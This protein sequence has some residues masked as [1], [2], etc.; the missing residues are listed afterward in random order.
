MSEEAKPERDAYEPPA[1]RMLG[2]VEE[3]TQAAVPGSFADSS[4]L[5]DPL[6]LGYRALWGD[7]GRLA[8]AK[9]EDRLEP[10]TREKDFPS[11]LNTPGAN[12]EDDDFIE[13][14]IYGAVHRRGVERVVASKKKRKAD[15]ALLKDLKRKLREI[16]VELE[17][18]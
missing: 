13:V 9:L 16:D 6:P 5:T 11:I 3:L 17:I 14:H 8:A 18:R 4:P 10:D 15:Q 12:R 2:S 7:R 1:L